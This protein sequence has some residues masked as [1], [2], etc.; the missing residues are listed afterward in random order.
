MLPSQELDKIN[1]QVYKVVIIFFIFIRMNALL[2]AKQAKVFVLAFAML[3][4]PVAAFPL[5][6][7]HA[8]A[9]DAMSCVTASFPSS[10]TA[11]SWFE[12][13]IT[14][15]NTGTTTIGPNAMAQGYSIP[16]ISWYG[17]AMPQFKKI[18]IDPTVIIRP[19][20]THTFKFYVY[21]PE[22]L[23]RYYM[24]TKAARFNQ[25]IA[26]DS[27]GGDTVVTPRAIL[28]G[29]SWKATG[30]Y[31]AFAGVPL[32]VQLT[33]LNDGTVPWD[34]AQGFVFKP[35]TTEYKAFANT[36]SIPLRKVVKPGEMITLNVLLFAPSRP[37]ADYYVY[38]VKGFQ[39]GGEVTGKSSWGVR[40]DAAMAR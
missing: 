32:E 12:G 3:A 1:T 15:R 6:S 34:P 37:T 23:G 7:V 20:E 11:G 38:A 33:F 19:G 2:S 24:V 21:S 13:Q 28:S 30:P 4:L 27:C 31:T 16:A 29:R 26:I 9:F 40:V 25:P 8:E 22:E 39:N 17:K 10:V 5:N 36:A 14:W 18:N 35:V